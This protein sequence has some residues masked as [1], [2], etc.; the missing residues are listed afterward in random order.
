MQKESSFMKQTKRLTSIIM[1]L[2][3]ALS[4][5]IPLAMPAA[6]AGD[7]VIT[8]QP[9]SPGKVQTGEK[10]TLTMAATAPAGETLKYQWYASYG[11]SYRNRNLGS[12]SPTLTTSVRER[13]FP[14]FGTKQIVTYRC[15]IT[16][17]SGKTVTSSTASVEAKMG[18]L[19]AFVH[20]IKITPNFLLNLSRMDLLDSSSYSSIFMLILPLFVP[21]IFLPIIPFI[22]PIALP[23]MAL[24]GL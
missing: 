7:I 1:A 23:I 24:V 15:K 5:A 20:G 2:A 18:A 10:F 17:S 4:L 19:D 12:N 16:S 21:I 13:D 3:L 8:K 9:L 11:T 14:L 22:A 6:A